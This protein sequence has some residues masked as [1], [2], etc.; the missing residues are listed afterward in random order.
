ML[1]SHTAPPHILSTLLISH[2]PIP[3]SFVFS[4]HNGLNLHAGRPR[5]RRGILENLIAARKSNVE[6]VSAALL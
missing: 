1:S 3:H 2:R 6:H 4:Y 5:E